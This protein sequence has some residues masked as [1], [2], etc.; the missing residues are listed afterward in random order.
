MHLLLLLGCLADIRTDAVRSFGED[1]SSQITGRSMLEAAAEAHGGLDAW[2]AHQTITIVAEDDWRGLIGHISSPWPKPHIQLRFEQRLHTFDSR[3]H[4]LDTKAAGS[5]WGITDWQ[6]WAIDADGRTRIRTSSDARFIL[7]TMQYFFALPF[8]ILE[9]PIIT[10]AGDEVLD[11]VTYS[12]VFATW[13]G[14]DPNR[15]YDQYIIYISQDSGLI[16]K[17]VYTIREL[18]GLVTGTMHYADFRTVGDMVIPHELTATFKPTDDVSDY[19]HKLVVE[20]VTLDALD[21]DSFAL[22]EL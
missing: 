7:P 21:P 22:P 16:E 17:A 2:S 3:V 4:F 12:R 8:R 20:S 11:G 9:A 19:L 18:S 15:T 13:E 5:T 10:D 1:A 6:T 14:L